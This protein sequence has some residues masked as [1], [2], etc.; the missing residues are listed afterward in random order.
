MTLS[1]TDKTRFLEALRDD[2]EFLQQ[3]RQYLLTAELIELPERFAAFASAVTSFMERQQGTN[4]EVATRLDGIDTRLD[5]IDTRLDGID[6]RLD[7]IDTRLDGID[8]RLH[9]IDTRLQQITDDLGD[10]KGH[11]AGRIAREMAD[12]IAE[13]LGYQMIEVLDSNDLRQMLRQQ[14]SADIAPGIRRSFYL[15]DLIGRVIDQQGNE[16]FLAAEASYTA[17]QR[18]TNR[19]IRNAELL[20]RFTGLTAVPVIAGRHNDHAVRSL[21]QAGT[22]Q[23]FEFDQR[24]L[25]PR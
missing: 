4:A 9:G 12:V 24:D 22:I 13:Q 17:D 6:T 15:A 1:G 5:G 2:P 11:T 18:D 23:W 3:V 20:T 14:D 10:L 19:A 16:I 8:T 25:S 21:V 7:G